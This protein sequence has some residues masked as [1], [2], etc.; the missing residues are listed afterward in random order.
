[1]GYSSI[2]AQGLIA[3]P[4]FL[5]GSI[6]ISSTW[7][8]DRTRQRGLMMTFLSVVGGIGYILLATEHSTAIRYTGVFL[9][10]AG[11]F[12]AIGNILP[13]V[14]DSQGNDTKRG[15]GMA[16][17]AADGWPMWINPGYET[18]PQDRRALRREGNECL[19]GVDVF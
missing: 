10:A 11:I 5:G 14:L 12:P 18:L 6:C 19:W 1:M 16:T 3:P 7:V 15:V 4:Y 17:L 13:W 8:A 2:N 9:A